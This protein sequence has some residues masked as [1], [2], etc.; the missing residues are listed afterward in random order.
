[1]DDLKFGL[2]VGIPLFVLLTM[3]VI[4]GLCIAK[5]RRGQELTH[6]LHSDDDE[7]HIQ[8]TFARGLAK[9][10][11]WDGRDR[12]GLYH[13]DGLSLGS[14]GRSLDCGR[15]HVQQFGDLSWSS[16]RNERDAEALPKQEQGNF[17]WDFLYKILEPSGQVN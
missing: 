1:N 10:G 5:N 14:S 2:A 4:I 6:S 3:A 9:R 12:L 11:T 13:H 15:P 7:S 16:S 8:S 17:S